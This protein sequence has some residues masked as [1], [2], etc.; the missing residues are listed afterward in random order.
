MVNTARQ[1]LKFLFSK[2]AYFFERSEYTS[3][4]FSEVLIDMSRYDCEELVQGSLRL[5]NRYYSAEIGLFHSSLQTQLLLT[6]E[7][8]R[9]SLP[10]SLSLSVAETDCCCGCLCVCVQVFKEIGDHL[11]VLR[12]LLNQELGEA[13]RAKVV[14][15]LQTFTDMC[16]LPS[17][18]SEPHTQNQ[19]I[20]YNFGQL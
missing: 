7:S 13:S 15:I 17:G 12:R 11:P 2:S 1:R 10:L 8:K 4:P 18:E 5:L 6:D 9:V 19:N 14:H 3:T 20:L 16:C